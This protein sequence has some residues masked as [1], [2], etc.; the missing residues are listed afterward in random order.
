MLRN[1]LG[2]AAMAVPYFLASIFLP[3]SDVALAVP[4]PLIGAAAGGLL[5]LFGGGGDQ[6]T[7]GFD[8]ATQAFIEQM[9]SRGINISDQF[10]GL[11]PGGIN[12]SFTPEDIARFR[13]PM[14]EDLLG[15]QEADFERIRER[16]LR[17]AQVEATL[18]GSGRGSGLFTR[19]GTTEANLGAAE[20]LQRAQTRFDADNQA[21]MRALQAAGIDISKLQGASGALSAGL[22]PV[23]TT[24]QTSGPGVF[25]RV[26][27]GA[28]SGGL[29]GA[30]ISSPA[31]NRV[32]TFEQLGGVHPTVGQPNLVDPS[33][34]FGG[35]GISMGSPQLGRFSRARRF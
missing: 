5:G 31:G 35:G 8:P 15:A 19:L 7:S 3:E 9:R 23:G 29:L 14:L 17:D 11:V 32:P 28:V 30:G 22:G 13:N 34:L 26:L 10:L 33:I 24:Q 18:A 16:A 1:I 27:G 4:L 6:T 25:E 20:A 12:P 21:A 2:F